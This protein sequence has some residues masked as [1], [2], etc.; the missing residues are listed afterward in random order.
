MSL[1]VGPLPP[2]ILLS[3]IRQGTL[4]ISMM[5]RKSIS[6]ERKNKP[7]WNALR[8]SRM[9]R[10]PCSDRNWSLKFVKPFL[11]SGS[12]K[13]YTFSSAADAPSTSEALR[14]S[15]DPQRRPEQLQGTS[16][17]HRVVNRGR[18]HLSLCVLHIGHWER[19]RKH[20]T[21]QCFHH[22]IC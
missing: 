13:G 2:P 5:T 9:P 12:L 16:I 6:L 11:A 4:G 15:G 21:P 7:Q 22:L 20:S 10:D 17:K 1:G 18:G 8:S 19:S 3:L 14:C